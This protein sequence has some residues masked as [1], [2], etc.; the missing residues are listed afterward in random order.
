MGTKV[1]IVAEKETTIK[2]ANF[3]IKFRYEVVVDSSEESDETKK[4]LNTGM[5]LKERIAADRQKK[6]DTEKPE[7]V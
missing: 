3:K 4:A 1:M 2:F 6:K 7:I 5:T